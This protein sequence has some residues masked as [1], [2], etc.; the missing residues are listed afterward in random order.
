MARSI[1]E[2]AYAGL[3]AQHHPSPRSRSHAA[4]SSRRSR[5]PVASPTSTVSRVRDAGID[6]FEYLFEVEVSDVRPFPLHV[7]R[8]TPDTLEVDTALH[9]PREAFGAHGA[10]SADVARRLGRLAAGREEVDLRVRFSLNPG[11]GSA[12]N[13]RGDALRPAVVGLARMAIKTPT[14]DPVSAAL[15]AISTPQHGP[16]V[17][18]NGMS[19]LNLVAAV[20]DVPLILGDEGKKTA[21]AVALLKQSGLKDEPRNRVRARSVFEQISELAETEQLD[22]I[23]GGYDSEIIETVLADLNPGDDDEGQ[24]N[25]DLLARQLITDI[26]KHIL[27]YPRRGKP[28]PRHP[29]D[30]ATPHR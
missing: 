24:G 29:R 6:G 14:G 7:A 26:V 13:R 3:H 11:N 22:A 28:K 1:P 30:V 16:A 2:T 8:A 25:R 9:R 12:A 17:A 5:D 21:I 23:F 10:A 15:H 4:R 27:Q 20:Y 19:Y 18:S